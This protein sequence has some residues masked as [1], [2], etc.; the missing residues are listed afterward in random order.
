MRG[1]DNS[2][3]SP[4]NADA[5][6]VQVLGKELTS[7]PGSVQATILKFSQRGGKT[8]GASQVQIPR[9]AKRILNQTE[10]STAAGSTPVVSTSESKFQRKASSSLEELHENGHPSG[11]AQERDGQQSRKFQSARKRCKNQMNPRRGSMIWCRPQAER[12][13]SLC[14]TPP[15]RKLKFK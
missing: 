7:M 1:W 9:G 12:R 4:Q 8:A 11:A 13:Q 15:R 3:C 6:R 10:A 5:H 14:E 2:E